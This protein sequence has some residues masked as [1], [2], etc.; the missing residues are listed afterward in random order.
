MESDKVAASRALQQNAKLKL[1]IEELQKEL[2]KLINSKAEVL[3]Q[4]EDHKR[5]LDN[6]GGAQSEINGL[7][8][9]IRFLL[10]TPFLIVIFYAVYIIT[11]GL[12][13]YVIG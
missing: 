2:M 5:K 8:E 10:V 9:G 12:Y 11:L 3:D 7:Q 6:M 1:E 4:L 13:V